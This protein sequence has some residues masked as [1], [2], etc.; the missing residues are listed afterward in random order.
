MKAIL[1]MVA[2]LFVTISSTASWAGQMIFHFLATVEQATI[3]YPYTIPVDERVY[4]VSPGDQFTFRVFYDLNREG[5]KTINAYEDPENIYP[6]YQAPNYPTPSVY[7]YVEGDP[8]NDEFYT[9]L[10]DYPVFGPFISN[11]YIVT[12]QIATIS[13]PG[14][15]SSYTQ[16]IT[17]MDQ[18]YSFGDWLAGDENIMFSLTMEHEL[19]GVPMYLS[20]TVD[21]NRIR[22]VPEPTTILLFGTGLAGLAGVSRQR[23]Q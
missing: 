7:H 6:I 11:P 19:Y 12:G 3:D 1:I 5:G 9:E 8:Y 2:L 10:M 21:I 4:P 14:Y 23:K 18:D 17:L 16:P 22:P 13:L 20:G 15:T